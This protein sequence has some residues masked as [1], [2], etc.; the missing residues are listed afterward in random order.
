[1]KRLSLFLLLSIAP[2][3]GFSQ[4][5]CPLGAGFQG[6]SPYSFTLLDKFYIGAYASALC[7]TPMNG[8]CTLDS[9]QIS[10]ASF[11]QGVTSGGVNDVAWY[12]GRLIVGG[13]FS[14]AGQNVP[15]T[16]RIAAWD[17]VAGWSSLTPNGG[18]NSFVN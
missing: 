13:E 10:A 18:V 2:Y 12:N 7:G 17:S 9:N 5:W 1:M 3:L 14:S 15:Y 8:I 6:G 4:V 16:A 11:G